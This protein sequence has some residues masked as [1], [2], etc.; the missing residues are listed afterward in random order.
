MPAPVAP[1]SCHHQI[2]PTQGLTL[3]RFTGTVS[4]GDVTRGIERLQAD[5]LYDP[6][7]N[8]IVNLAGVT[9]RARLDDLRALLAYL[10]K[11]RTG[12]G[13]WAVIFTEPKLVALALCFKVAWRGAFR[14]EIVSTW[15]AACRCL[16]VTLPQPV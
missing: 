3:M 2:L 1:K 13:Q 11:R 9:T 8:G 15:E 12:S 10:E 7:Y 16:G 4:L 14:I 5:P 6:R